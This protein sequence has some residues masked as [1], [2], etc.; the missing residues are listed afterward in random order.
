MGEM[1]K[2]KLNLSPEYNLLKYCAKIHIN[3]GIRNRLKDIL[4][5][6]LSWP[7]IVEESIRQGIACLVYN[8]LLEFKDK[9]PGKI[10]NN[11]KEIYYLNASRNIRIYQEISAILS[12]FNKENLKVIPLKGIFLA[13]KVYNNIALRTM[14]D[15]DLLVRKENLSRIDKFLGNLGYASPIHKNILSVAI[16]KSYMN[17]IDYFKTDEESPTENIL[18]LHVHWHIVNVSLPTYMYTKNIK[19]DRFWECAKPTKIGNAETLQ[20]VP[21]QLI[22]YL[23][24]HALK[25]SFDKLILLSDIDAVIKKY[26]GQI[27]W[28][29]LIK[30]AI[31]FG[32]ERQV[33]Y[34]LYFTNYFLDADIPD[35]ILS[36]LRPKKI[37]PLEKWFFYSIL[38]NNRKAQLCYFVYLNT[39]KGVINKFRFI[40]RTIFPP[41]CSLALFFNLDKP[42]ITVKDYLLFLKKRL[43]LLK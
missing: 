35:N 23:S 37:G 40:F 2:T 22:M 5:N 34:A 38:N 39:V 3:N 10:W 1:I 41:P 18:T 24:E 43:S 19:M 31:E 42:K 36:T 15:I 17:S 9:I 7:Y 28:Q 20:L 25:H 29:E 33:F 27:N 30:E 13:E 32:M 4:N 11:I 16:E 8:N 14:G 26:R 21:H 6:N 12:S